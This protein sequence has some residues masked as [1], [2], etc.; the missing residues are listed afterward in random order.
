MEI[1]MIDLGF[2][3]VDSVVFFAFI[4]A[5]VA[6]ILQIFF[7]FFGHKFFVRIL[8]IFLLL[9]CAG[10]LALALLFGFFEGWE[11]VGILLLAAYVAVL[12]AICT[13]MSVICFII[14]K[15]LSI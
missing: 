14:K 1:N 11:A 12:G 4:F 15:V 8:P 5:V 9:V 13:A 10:V 2:T 6:A 3:Q 7:S